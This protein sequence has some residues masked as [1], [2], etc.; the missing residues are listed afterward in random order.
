[1]RNATVLKYPVCNCIGL[2]FGTLLFLFSLVV[3]RCSE[4][5]GKHQCKCISDVCIDFVIIILLKNEM[6]KVLS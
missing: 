4:V 2:L 5:G 1:M 6:C 3:G